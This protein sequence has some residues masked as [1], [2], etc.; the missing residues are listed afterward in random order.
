MQFCLDTGEPGKGK[1]RCAWPVCFVGDLNGGQ[2]LSSTQSIPDRGCI[3]M[4][5]LE[6]YGTVPT[7]V[8]NRHH[9][10]DISTSIMILAEALLRDKYMSV[11]VMAALVAQSQHWHARRNCPLACSGPLRDAPFKHINTYSL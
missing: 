9:G 3:Y 2:W 4:C 10:I 6:G 1:R 7:L 5:G 11:V 8:V